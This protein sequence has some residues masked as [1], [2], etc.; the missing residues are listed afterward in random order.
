VL[1]YFITWIVITFILF[2]SGDILVSIYNKACKANEGEYNFIDKLLLGLCFLI[3]P[4]SVWSLWLPSNHFF[5]V[6]VFF[7]CIGYWGINHRKALSILSG[8]KKKIRGV[9]SPF[10][11]II[12]IVSILVSVFF[13][14]WQQ[15]VFDSAFYH[16]QNI[17]WN[18]EY[19]VVPGLANLE[20]KL[21]FNSNYFLISAI[22][23]FRF[24][25]N[26]AIYPLHPLI[27]TITTTWVLY[28]LFR[29]GYEIKRFFIFIAYI[30]LFWVSIYFLGNTSTDIT[31]NFIVFYIL[32]RIILY[33][34]LLKKNYFFGIILP[35][36]LVTIKLSFFPL[37]IISLY[38]LYYLI[39]NKKYNI[40]II[41]FSV[42]ISLL[43]VVPWLIRNVIVSGYLIYPLHEIDLFSFDWKVPKDIAIKEKDYIFEI[44]YYFFRIALRYPWMSVRDSLWINILT[45]IIYLLTF[46][47]FAIFS[48]R[49]IKKGETVASHIRL[50]YAVFALSI[51]V[52]ATGGPDVRFVAGILCSCIFTGAILLFKNKPIQ[53][54]GFS[55]FLSTAFITSVFIWTINCYYE[56]SSQ[57]K[58]PEPHLVSHLLLEPYSKKDQ[59]LAKGLNQAKNFYKYPINN[60]L[61]IWAGPFPP[62]DMPLPATI[63]SHHSKFLPIE[64]IEA[65]GHTIQEGFRAKEECK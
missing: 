37:G 34:G 62:Y 35:V 57:T 1:A 36:F 52:W 18:E 51:I 49:L 32:A 7:I 27:A 14:T 41:S 44:G 6:I 26:E 16:Y 65:R 11:I 8:A 4:L 21:G 3:I 58:G 59:Q 40:N 43:I 47:S 63:H 19:A 38:S 13:F 22:F 23:S 17:R 61:F 54:K 48:Y 15:D 42:I 45:D 33:P 10:Q 24:I 46:I 5:L 29:S 50:L 25:L 64:C 60:D 31:S 20:G 28:E 55:K 2:T 53:I 56:F 30:L 12:L 9:S 39:R